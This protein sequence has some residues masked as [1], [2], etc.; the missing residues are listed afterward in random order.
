VKKIKV[1][2]IGGLSFWLAGIGLLAL[3]ANSWLNVHSDSFL[4]SFMVA[5]TWIIG[6]PIAL[7]LWLRAIHQE[8]ERK[9]TPRH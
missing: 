3:S 8:Q 2:G 1:V 7:S 4:W 5:V 9:G 6:V